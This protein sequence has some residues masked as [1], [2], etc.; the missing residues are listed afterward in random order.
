[1]SPPEPPPPHA[2]SKSVNKTEPTPAIRRLEITLQPSETLE[3]NKQELVVDVS[4]L[5]GAGET[6]ALGRRRVRPS[7]GE[8]QGT[9]R[10]ERMVV[11][12]CRNGRPG[13][14]SIADQLGVR[15]CVVRDKHLS[16]IQIHERLR[17]SGHGVAP[18]I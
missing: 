14:E 16:D 5:T 9:K 11:A 1:M 7:P 13:V 18:A 15:I 4:R 17:P 8:I 12:N 3:I 6:W 10:T 2:A